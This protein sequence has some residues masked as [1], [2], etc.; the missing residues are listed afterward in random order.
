[1]LKKSLNT[2]SHSKDMLQN[3]KYKYDYLSENELA[4]VSE[5]MKIMN[6]H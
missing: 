5:V 3:L 4:L 1:M 2:F 6:K